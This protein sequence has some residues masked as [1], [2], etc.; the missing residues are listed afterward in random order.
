[1]FDYISFIS[2]GIICIIFLYV[3]YHLHPLKYRVISINICLSL[4]IPYIIYHLTIP[5]NWKIFA[6]LLTFLFALFHDSPVKQLYTFFM[7]SIIIIFSKL[8][9][10]YLF[11][12]FFQMTLMNNINIL[13]NPFSFLC[14]HI[15]IF[16]MGY[17]YMK[18]CHHLKIDMLPSFS[19]YVFVLPLS[20][21]LLMNNIDSYQLMGENIAIFIAILGLLLSNF[22]TLY[23]FLLVVRY[24]T[25]KNQ[26][27]EF[28]LQ[29]QFVSQ[30]LTSH[31]HF[32]HK[33]INELNQI[34]TA[35]PDENYKVKN[36]LHHLI[37]ETYEQFNV[38]YTNSIALNAVI[39]SKI[40]DIKDY[41]I[42]FS[43][44][45][46]YLDFNYLN[47]ESQIELFSY[48]LDIAIEASQNSKEKTVILK[49]KKQAQQLL[50][51]LTFSSSKTFFLQ[52]NHIKKTLSELIKKPF[53]VSTNKNDLYITI[54]IM[55]FKSKM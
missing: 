25:T 39:N 32:L 51:T 41:H 9:T 34:I 35:L 1:M 24:F 33:L 15:L 54:M 38:M 27:R 48:L 14:Y 16:I 17:G 6:L 23:I 31:F 30:H 26:I 47:Y 7:F 42:Q 12:G 10:F 36:Q 21:I 19:W 45:I 49:S 43:H 52:E 46:M 53:A 8:L 44:Q 20:T 28:K 11:D 18:E 55:I 2:N 50:I 37:Q 4:V 29:N 3:S 22:I 5:V 13:K 40:N